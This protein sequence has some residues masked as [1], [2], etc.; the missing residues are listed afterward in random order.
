MMVVVMTICFKEKKVLLNC[1]ICQPLLS[2]NHPAH[3]FHQRS[4]LPIY[5]YIS[6][7]IYNIYPAVT[8]ASLAFSTKSGHGQTADTM[9]R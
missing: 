9:S 6:I 2:K 4:Q 7:Y 3:I 8:T 1:D 5:D